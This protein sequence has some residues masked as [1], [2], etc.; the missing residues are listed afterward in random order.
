MGLAAALGRILGTRATKL[1]S[2]PLKDPA[3]AALLGVR[4]LSSSGVAVTP[5]TALALS[6]VYACV[7]VLAES[8]ASLPLVVYRRRADGGRTR[9]TDHP[10]YALLHDAPNRWQTSVEWREMM[11]GHLA[12]RGNAYAL[13]VD[14]ARSG[15]ITGLVPLDPR[16][17]RPFATPDGGI[18]YEWLP[19]AGARTILLPREVLHL[20]GLTK[21]GIVGLS[22]I[23]EARE[24]IGLGLA[25]Q[26]YG[27]RL[28]ANDAQPRG[29]LKTGEVL[30]DDATRALLKAWE[31]RHR[32]ASNAHRI[33]VLEGGMEWVQI[34]MTNEDAQFLELRRY[35]D[36]DV[37]RLFRMP[38]HK[39]GILDRATFSNI[40]QQALE[41]VQDALLPHVRRWESRLTLSLLSDDDRRTHYVEFVM[42]G[43][44]RGDF[45]SRMAGYAVGRQWGWLSVNDIR[46][47]ENLDPVADG[48]VYLAPLNM[49]PSPS[50][51]DILMKGKPDGSGTPRVQ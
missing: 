42:D 46:R 12:L 45:A 13:I 4:A 20:R 38:P 23:E 32:G 3:L 18:A 6:A 7:K 16:R 21:D 44:L 15:R 27:A 19:D 10:L 25:A 43:L 36:T 31:E 14:D 11:M 49:A 51:L 17:V 34:G 47:M 29:I 26:E 2:R 24:T 39:I 8:I 22:P 37:A 9:A 28:F 40:E 5:D 50:L 35:Q 33:A 1:P 41:F 30:G 48:D